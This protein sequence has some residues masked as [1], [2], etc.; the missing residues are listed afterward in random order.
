M[1]RRRKKERNEGEERR[2]KEVITRE[3]RC[4]F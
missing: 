2:E 4:T 3:L 1:E